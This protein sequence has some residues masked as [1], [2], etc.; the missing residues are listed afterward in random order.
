MTS[1]E[2]NAP[3]V[4]VASAPTADPSTLPS[5]S[6]VAVGGGVDVG[7]VDIDAMRRN[8]M[9]DNIRTNIRKPGAGEKQDLGFL[10]K[11]ECTEKGAYFY[12]RT[13]TQTLKLLN[14]SPKDLSIRVFTPDLEGVRFG[15]NAKI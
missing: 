7:N 14:L 15:C 13:A 10:D 6:G 9:M 1:D 8:A 12:M 2:L 4:V 5:T 11:I 3:T